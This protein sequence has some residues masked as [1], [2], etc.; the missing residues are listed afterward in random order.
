MSVSSVM[1]AWKWDILGPC[2]CPPLTL[3]TRPA[4]EDKSE[5][6]DE[7]TT[8]PA[9]SMS[10]YALWALPA[11]VLRLVSMSKTERKALCL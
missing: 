10:E 11:G 7:G 9:G 2:S 6:R 1:S 3:R 8:A 5:K 4:L